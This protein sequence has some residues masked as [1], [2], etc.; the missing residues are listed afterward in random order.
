VLLAVAGFAVANTVFAAG[1]G[2]ACTRASSSPSS[3]AQPCAKTTYTI[4]TAT[5]PASTTTRWPY[6][7]TVKGYY[8]G[9]SDQLR[10]WKRYKAYGFNL[11]FAGLNMRLL[12][13]V[14]AD[15]ATAWVQPDV[16]TGCGYEYSI[17]HALRRAG[18]AV[19]TGAV[20]GFY[21]ADEPSVSGC[22]SAPAQIAAWTAILHS[23][24]PGIPTVIATFDTT[25]L[26]DFAHSADM[27]ALDTYP[28][29]YGNGCDY[30]RI[31]NLAAAAD[32]LGLRYV[33]VAQAFGGDGH[34]D[35]P[36]ASQLRQIIHT[37]E[38]T[39][40]LGYAVY[41]FSAGGMP[42]STWLQNDPALLSV[43]AAN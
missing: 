40:E 2:S 27:F 38:A 32:R 43:I 29:Q 42:S 13:Q 12:H 26:R 19:A 8:D 35:L 16:W 3:A 10:D 15:G 37:W 18:R 23:H 5:P 28:C 25:E 4:P 14:R 39:N 1:T 41:A 11:V 21:V 36:T 9:G 6:D 20:S 33:G 30:S 7:A 24:F 34:Y 22:S 17:S 31:A